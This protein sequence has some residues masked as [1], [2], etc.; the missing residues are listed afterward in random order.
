MK[1]ELIKTWIKTVVKITPF[2]QPN[3]DQTSIVMVN[4]LRCA[5]REGVWRCFA[6]HVTDT[7]TRQNFQAP[8]AHPHLPIATLFFDCFWVS[9]EEKERERKKN[10]MMALLLQYD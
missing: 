2:I 7:R 8:T 9:N 5:A 3:V 10:T 6:E 1:R 4:D